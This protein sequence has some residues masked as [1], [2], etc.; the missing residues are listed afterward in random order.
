MFKR[1]QPKPKPLPF[2]EEQIRDKAYEIWKA[3]KG[4][5]G[6]PEEDWGAAIAA[7]K[8]ERALPKRMRRFRHTFKTDEDRKLALELEN[9][10]QTKSK[11]HFSSGTTRNRLRWD[12]PIPDL[13]K[14]QRTPGY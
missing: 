7:L 6:S 4:A 1:K 13:S 5:N 9:S 12:K 8:S 11:P 10:A 3:R 14:Q 2:T